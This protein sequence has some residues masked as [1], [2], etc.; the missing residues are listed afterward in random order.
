MIVADYNVF[1]CTISSV[2]ADAQYNSKMKLKEKQ[3]TPSTLP[4]FNYPL[5]IGGYLQTCWT[6]IKD[7][8]YHNHAG[9]GEEAV[10]HICAC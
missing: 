3:S 7:R 2:S 10:G 6:G 9:G 8:Q 1:K 4:V 5:E